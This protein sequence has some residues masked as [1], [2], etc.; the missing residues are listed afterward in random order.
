MATIIVI[1]SGHSK[2]VGKYAQGKTKSIT[3]I[4]ATAVIIKSCD[5]LLKY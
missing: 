2:A 4:I 1:K 3:S 5:F